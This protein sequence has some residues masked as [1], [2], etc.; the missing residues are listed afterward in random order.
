MKARMRM[1]W[2]A[3]A[4]AAVAL[5]ACGGGGGNTTPAQNVTKIRV[6]GDSL[7]D[8][9][10]FGFKATVQNAGNPD[11]ANGPSWLWV[12]HVAK[13]YGV[14]LCSHYRAADA[15]TYTT[16]ASCN[17]FAVAGGRIN[18][19]ANP[20]D[21]HSITKQ[22][23]DAAATAYNAEELVLIDGGG[24]DAGDLFGAYL[25]ASTDGGK[26][27]F[28]L[29]GTMLD[30][31]TVQ[32]LAAQ[33]AAGMPKAGAAYMQALA[34]YFARNIKTNVLDKGAPRVAVLNMPGVTLT[35]KFQMVLKRITATQGAAAAQQLN[36][37]FDTWV[38]TFNTQLGTSLG[39]DSRLA[40]V[41]FYDSFRDQ[42][43]N[44][45]QYSYQNVTDPVCPPTGQDASGLPTYTFTSCTAQALSARTP[46]TGA[47][48]GANWW[49]SYGFADSFHPTPYGQQLMSQ[50]AS[51]SLSRA[52]WY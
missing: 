33:G 3:A 50:L 51:R 8:T 20:K 35:P 26:S 47:S 52:G 27:F 18:Y 38:Q 40:L 16:V 5:T 49:R 24:N 1:H 21:P 22:M 25:A 6:M 19:F 29:I 37:L 17:N 14:P 12:E 15:S 4:V 45:S 28:A 42:A 30:A 44:P 46:P 9:G 10:T 41:D 43:A 48:G 39:T 23:A 11:D 31:P 7:S 13:R 36:T 34:G 32:A 2:I